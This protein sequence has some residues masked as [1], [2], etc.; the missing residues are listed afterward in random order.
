M[1][2]KSGPS[3]QNNFPTISSPSMKIERQNTGFFDLPPD[4]NE[5]SLTSQSHSAPNSHSG[6]MQHAKSL[7]SQHDTD[8]DSEDSPKGPHW[9]TLPPLPQKPQTKNTRS[10]QTEYL[11]TIIDGF[12]QG[13][14]SLQEINTSLSAS[15]AKMIHQDAQRSDSSTSRTSHNSTN[16]LLTRRASFNKRGSKAEIIETM[17][18][19]I[20]VLLS[21][22]ETSPE[23]ISDENLA[24]SIHQIFQDGLSNLS[25]RIELNKDKTNMIKARIQN[26]IEE[27]KPFT[28]PSS[29]PT[30][31]RNSYR[32]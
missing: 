14:E 5:S 30:S 21:Q 10:A 15:P 8:D 7:T 17:K 22:R 4:P 13:L 31:T 26:F 24:N 12:V 25:K 16:S 1:S 23:Q 2:K 20:L 19:K 18:T 6:M 32:N 28:A 27:L 11:L 9:F 29:A 3:T